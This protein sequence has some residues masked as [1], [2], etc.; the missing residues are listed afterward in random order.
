MSN[1]NKKDAPK[2]TNIAQNNE[3]IAWAVSTS[4]LHCSLSF[5]NTTIT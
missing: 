1:T 4:L 3:D 5:V 2:S